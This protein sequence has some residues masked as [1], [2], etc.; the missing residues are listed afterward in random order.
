MKRSNL[1]RDKYNVGMGTIFLHASTRKHVLDT[2]YGR[3]TIP[4]IVAIENSYLRWHWGCAGKT[5][6]T[7]RRWDK[8]RYT[9][10]QI[11]RL[12]FG[13]RECGNAR[14]WLAAQTKL[15][16][17]FAKGIYQAGLRE[18]YDKIETRGAKADLDWIELLVFETAGRRLFTIQFGAE[19]LT[20][21]AD[22]TTDQ[23]D[24]RMGVQSMGGLSIQQARFVLGQAIAAWGNGGSLVA[25]EKL[26]IG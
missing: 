21:I 11:Y 25:D 20:F 3:G 7:G 5:K 6:A 16:K 22:A 19:Q 13:M 10:W 14:A 24:G 1:I 9:Q 26:G 15:A 2:A 8:R 18:Q 4:C 17:D 12:V 23:P